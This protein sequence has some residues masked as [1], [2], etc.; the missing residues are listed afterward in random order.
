MQKKNRLN[1]Q[2][3][4]TVSLQALSQTTGIEH[5]INQIYSSKKI[6]REQHAYLMSS[7]LSNEAQVKTHRASINRIFEALH[8][9][10]LVRAD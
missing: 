4:R 7:L 1:N 10:H 9:G 8:A 2:S 3:A 6:N 5:V